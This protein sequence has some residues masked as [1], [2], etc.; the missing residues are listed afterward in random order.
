V[1][2]PVMREELLVIAPPAHPLA[3]RRRIVPQD[4]VG[5]PFVLFEAGSA[6]RRELVRAFD[7]VRDRLRLAPLARRRTHHEKR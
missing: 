1:T 5:Q 2:V 3:R 7:D 6:T 4:L